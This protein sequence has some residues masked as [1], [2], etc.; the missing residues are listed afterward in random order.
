MRR[1]LI[2]ARLHGAA[3]SLPLLV[4]GLVLVFAVA[5]P[6]FFSLDNLQQL[7]KDASALAILAT[8]EALVVIAGGFDLSIGAN[9]SVVSIVSAS[10]AISYGTPAGIGAGLIAGLIIGAANGFLV[11]VLRMSPFIVTLAV[12]SI[13]ASLAFIWTNG[14]PVFGMSSDYAWAATGRLGPVPLSAL[15]AAF[16][17]TLLIGSARLTPFGVHVYATGSNATAARLSGLSPRRIL[18]GVYTLNGVVAATAGIMLSSR[19]FSGQPALAPGIEVQVLAAVFLAGV[20]LAGGSG[21]LIQVLLAVILLQVLTNGLTLLGVQTYLQSIV[22]GVVLIFAIAVQHF[23]RQ[24]I[25]RRRLER[26]RAL[27]DI[28]QVDQREVTDVLTGG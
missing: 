15:V 21:S 4:L 20:S 7:L 5:S 8:G 1:L 6:V 25:E 24:R 26:S 23:V 16:V 18:L 17:L 13:L 10:V 14:L 19:V 22:A 11:A 2:A 9:M 3:L 12:Q 27:G 28:V